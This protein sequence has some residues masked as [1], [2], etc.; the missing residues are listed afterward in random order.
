MGIV[1]YIKESLQE[2]NTKVTWLSLPEAQKS[3]VVV[4]VFTVLFA[5]AVFLVDKVFQL[6]LEQYFKLF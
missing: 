5:I 2:L 6:G 4:A 1:T 3:T